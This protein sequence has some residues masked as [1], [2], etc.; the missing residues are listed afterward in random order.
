MSSPQPNRGGPVTPF[1]LVSLDPLQGPLLTLGP[2]PR[3]PATVNLGGAGYHSRNPSP[4]LAFQTGF[5]FTSRPVRS[6]PVRKSRRQP[7]L[8]PRRCQ[9]RCPRPRIRWSCSVDGRPPP[10]PPRPPPRT[11]LLAPD[12]QRFHCAVVIP[13]PPRLRR[14]LQASVP[15]TDSSTT[16]SWSLPGEHR[17]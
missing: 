17:T 6:R 1:S 15:H 11:R 4:R 16:P 12:H 14:R 13:E 9:P 2:G 10:S 5:G 3:T 8:A 7:D